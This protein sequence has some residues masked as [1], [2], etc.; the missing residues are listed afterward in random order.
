MAGL[1]AAALVGVFTVSLVR[2]VPFP[3]KSVV[4]T[5]GPEGGAYRVLGE[6][7]R[8]ALARDGID[9]KLVTSLGNVENLARLDDPRSDVAAGFA[10]GGLTTAR[11]SPGLV[12]LGTISYE[13]L[14]IFCRHFRS[15]SSSPRCAA[16]ASRSAP[17]GAARG[18]SCSP[19]SARAGSKAPSR[20]SR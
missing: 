16:G 15:P 14:W 9:L 13:P 8:R 19:S 12:S 17:K 18:R 11:A 4:M 6:E 7:Y 1:L 5:T 2:L 20:R 3:P 10:S